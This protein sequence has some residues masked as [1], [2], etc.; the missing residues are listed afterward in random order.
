MFPIS[1]GNSDDFVIWEARG[2]TLRPGNIY[3]VSP[4]IPHWPSSQNSLPDD[5]THGTPIYTRLADDVLLVPVI[6][7]FWQR[8]TATPEG[9]AI[10]LEDLT[11][12]F[13]LFD[14]QG[15][16]EAFWAGGVN[17]ER[18]DQMVLND[19][20]AIRET[21]PD[22]IWAQ[23]GIQFQ[24]IGGM[25]FEDTIPTK[26]A[27]DTLSF[28][29]NATKPPD[30]LFGEY[31]LSF[32]NL[33]ILEQKFERYRIATAQTAAAAA[34]SSNFN[35]KAGDIPG[36]DLLQLFPLIQALNPVEYN[37]GNQGCASSRRGSTIPANHSVEVDSSIR[38]RNT[39]AHEL[40]HI[41]LGTKKHCGEI[42]PPTTEDCRRENNLMVDF[43][44][45]FE[46]RVTDCEAARMT[47][48]EYSQRFRVY[49]EEVQKWEVISREC[50]HF[51]DG[52]QKLVPKSSCE[53]S[54][55][56]VVLD[57][58]TC[59]YVEAVMH[60]NSG[61]PV[62]GLGAT[63]LVCCETNGQFARVA[64]GQCSTT[65]VPD[66]QCPSGSAGCSAGVQPCG[67]PGDASCL[68]AFTC[69]NGCC[70]HLQ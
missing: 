35:L 24:V 1:E 50:C 51:N 37:L 70:I 48:A 17:G 45:G 43:G 23:C 38:L 66:D 63:Q 25:V 44:T 52:S 3:N 39:T 57:P 30:A 32:S 22:D 68:A 42:A 2:G 6:V 64:A 62:D 11:Q 27:T 53:A 15:S 18:F 41:L 33:Q 8:P 40:G 55:G 54:G 12:A 49:S 47:A 61:E 29:D 16:Q 10:D 69:S 13:R 7:N 9:N 31:G 19:H 56:A 5:V 34:S 28:H 4:G 46:T 58:N 60:N 36:V 59:T 67:S 20:P 65:I 21:A 14:F 26:C